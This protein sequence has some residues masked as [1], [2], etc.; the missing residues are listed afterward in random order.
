MDG[1]GN[2]EMLD[3]G[4]QIVGIVIHVVALPGCE[5]RPWPRRSCAMQRK[6]WEAGNSIWS[7]KAL[8]L[9]GQP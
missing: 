2:H 9:S 4:G 6:P 7:S 1:P 5:E 8:A 3:E